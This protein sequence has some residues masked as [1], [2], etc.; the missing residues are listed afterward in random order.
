MI[1][2]SW[3]SKK[4]TAKESPV[5]GKGVFAVENISAGERVAV[6]G[7]YTLSFEDL[8]KLEKTDPDEFEAILDKAI[9]VDTDILFSPTSESQYSDIEYLNHSCNPNTGFKGQLH[10]IGYPS[11]TFFS[12]GTD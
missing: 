2:I 5:S 1:S 8:D 4:I 6:F 9:Q 3:T 7:G 10:L 11:N 12:V